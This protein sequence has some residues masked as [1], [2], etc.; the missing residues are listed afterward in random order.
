[1]A[2]KNSSR[3]AIIAGMRTPFAKAGGYFKNY[4]A[5]DLGVHAVKGLIAKQQL[6]TELIEDL[7][8]GTV[9]HQPKIPNLAREIIFSSRLPYTIPAYTVSNNCISGAQA[10][11]NIH[12]A[13]VTGQIEVG[14]AGGSEA[15]SDIPILFQRR[16]ARILLN[17]AGEK[18]FI[19]KLKQFLK[20]RPSYLKPDVMGITEPSTG[21]SMGEHCELMAKQWHVGRLEQDEL[22]YRSQ[23][24]A[25]RATQ[26]GRLKAEIYPLDGFDYDPIIRPN[27]TLEKM[28][29]LPPVFD[30]SPAGT[31]TAGNSSPLTDGASAVL[32]ASEKFAAKMGWE[33]L[34]FIKGFDYAAIDPADGL[35]MATAIAVPR[36]L[37]K[38]GLSLGD[39]EII[40]I[41]EAF[42]AEVI[43]NIKA[44]EQ[45][46]R[47]NP[48]GPVSPELL[49]PLGSSIAVGHPF[50]ATGG[51][52][53]TTLANE[54]R[55]RNAKYGLISICGAGAMGIAMILERN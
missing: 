7:I 9:I 31:I 24:N 18:T 4:T 32:L 20:L 50:A 33:P 41:H 42:A 25:W 1:M 13:I 40:E 22:A 46:W 23:M 43:C 11:T 17:A 37:E 3:V 53:I 35:L 34:A 5:L 2:V 15:M 6:D 8:F 39:M 51:R 10:V 19:G 45:G 14:I 36:L 21:L 49:N 44:W 26:D 28:A 30:R 29:K 16:M 38:T 55:R 12:D 52:I 48:T 54:M 27:T 47:G